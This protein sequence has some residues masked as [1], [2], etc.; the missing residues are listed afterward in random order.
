M[1]GMRLLRWSPAAVVTLL[2]YIQY[3]YIRKHLGPTS[4]RQDTQ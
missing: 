2:Y 1:V 4:L 3:C